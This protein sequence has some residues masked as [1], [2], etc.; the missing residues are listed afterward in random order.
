MFK[1]INLKIIMHTSLKIGIN[2]HYSLY[3]LKNNCKSVNI[4]SLVMI[5]YDSILTYLQLFY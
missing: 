1:I 2:L 3:L 4:L 5:S